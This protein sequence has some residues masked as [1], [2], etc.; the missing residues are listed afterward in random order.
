MPAP[1]QRTLRNRRRPRRGGG[2]GPGRAPVSEYEEMQEIEAARERNGLDV[3]DLRE[4]SVAELRQVGQEL[5]LDTRAEER[6]DDLVE[7]ILRRQTEN[8]GLDYATGILD[9]VD[10]G[11]GFLRR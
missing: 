11:Y 10:E 2:G 4:M 7:E 8:A 9:V 3:A 5:E 6:K 1:D